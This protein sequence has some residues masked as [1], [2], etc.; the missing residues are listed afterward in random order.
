MASAIGP[1]VVANSLERGG[2][3]ESVGVVR[4]QAQPSHGPAD[5]RC[6]GV[7]A[8]RPFPLK[9]KILAGDAGGVTRA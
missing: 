1:A 8:A 4:A 7:G 3:G 5:C 6:G 9:R 2:Q